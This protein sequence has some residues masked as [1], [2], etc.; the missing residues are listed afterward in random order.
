[1]TSPPAEDRSRTSSV[2]GALRLA[3]CLALCLAL[4]SVPAA[5]QWWDTREQ[6][7]EPDYP[8]LTVTPG[9]LTGL[10]GRRDVVVLDARS[11]EDY[12][13]GHI[14]GAVPIPATDIPPVESIHEVENLPELLG[15]L[16]LTGRERLVC[17][18]AS[19]RS[20]DAALLFW[21]LEL[22]GAADVALLE[23]G[24]GE[25]TQSG[26]SLSQGPV[27]REP[28]V[29]SQTPNL[30]VLATREYVRRQYGAR[31]FEIVDAR[32]T[33]AWRG[34]VEQEEW[35]DPPRVGHIPHAL[36]F[37]FGSFY[38]PRG[39]MLDAADCWT[40]FG[41]LG[42]R[43]ANPVHLADEF[44]VHGWGRDDAGG[45]P[46]GSHAPDG[47]PLAYF[48]LRRAGI[49]RVRL[50]PGGWSDW[51]GDPYLPVVRIIGAEELAQRL[52][53]EHRWLRPSA[54][55]ESFAFFDVRHPSDHGRR[56]IRGSVTL[57]SDFFADSI[58][59]R[60]ERYWPELDRATSPVVTYCYGDNCI[61]SRAASTDAARAGFIRIE[62]FM[63]GLDE[64]RAAGEVLVPGE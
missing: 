2:D 36:P 34:P 38:A 50:Y 16:G 26:H 62:R 58:D 45:Y 37:D 41:T 30:D 24:V 28:A 31:G 17:A 48:L 44:I 7:P 49:A 10:L 27:L 6:I 20:E 56:H 33:E 61:R 51:E 18:G 39:E 5:A 32:G 40:L 15:G 4:A 14:S 1:M 35:G 53:D 13:A 19:S 12:L 25:W 46:R 52:R 8:E 55:P 59:V 43:P 54:P 64:W 22:A 57:R 47:G 9:Q 60:L 42:P 63:G 23:G 11:T 29:W 21:T 3:T